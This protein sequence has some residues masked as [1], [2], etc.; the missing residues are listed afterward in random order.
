MRIAPRQGNP[1]RI[2]SQSGSL[3]IWGKQGHY[4]SPTARVGLGRKEVTRALSRARHSP[5]SPH[6]CTKSGK[7]TARSGQCRLLIKPEHLP[8]LHDDAPVDNTR[9]HI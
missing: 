2:K 4:L 8:I 7:V 6:H 3:E 5:K 9:N 1:L